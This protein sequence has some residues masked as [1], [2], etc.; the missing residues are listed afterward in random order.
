MG[1]SPFKERLHSFFSKKSKSENRKETSIHPEHCSGQQLP[2]RNGVTRHHSSVDIQKRCLPMLPGHR[3][4]AGTLASH[5]TSAGSLPRESSVS[6][7][8][9][10]RES[11]ALNRCSLDRLA[12]ANF[13]HSPLHDSA[14][15]GTSFQYNHLSVHIST[16]PPSGSRVSASSTNSLTQP[17]FSSSS[18]LTLPRCNYAAGK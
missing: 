8:T 17:S 1:S 9:S 4:S 3:S 2:S 6:V 15:S 13:S 10:A 11:V 18:A 12:T 16:S 14:G 5:R 7:E